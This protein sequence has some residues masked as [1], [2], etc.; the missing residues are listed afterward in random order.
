MTAPRQKPVDRPVPVTELEVIAGLGGK[1]KV[2]VERL[3]EKQ[4]D[5]RHRMEIRAW[6]YRLISLGAGLAVFAFL[7]WFA[8]RLADQGDV[9]EAVGVVGFG[10]LPMVALFVTGEVV[11]R[12][13]LR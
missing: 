1:Q 8:A 6:Y 5:H 4:L 3:F 7:A 9:L 13:M 12:R 2:D 10:G 11:S